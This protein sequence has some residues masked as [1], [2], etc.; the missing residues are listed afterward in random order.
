M[1]GC[2]ALAP[3]LAARRRPSARWRTRVVNAGNLRWYR[4]MVFGRSPG[5]APGPGAGG[6]VAPGPGACA[7]TLAGV[8]ALEVR[9]RL[10]GADGVLAVERRAARARSSARPRAS[11]ANAWR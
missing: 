2:R 9:P 7:A 4:T 3:L 1:I 6:A 5:F 8:R 11:P 10:Q